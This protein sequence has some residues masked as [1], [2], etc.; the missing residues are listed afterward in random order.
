LSVHT[1]LAVLVAALV[2]L[3][4]LAWWL[5]TFD[6]RAVGTTSVVVSDGVDFDP[7]A[8]ATH[9][10]YTGSFEIERARRVEVTLWASRPEPIGALVSLVEAET[11]DVR[12]GEAT[13]DDR[14]E[15]RVVFDGVPP[16]DYRLRLVATRRARPDTRAQV[17]LRLTARVGGGS[18]SALTIAAVLLAVP[19]V[20][21]TWRRRSRGSHESA[22]M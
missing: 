8:L 13:L 12:E 10:G 6:E 21:R 15:A 9:V 17:Q 20:A 16:G 2:S 11:G 5:G 3:A 4:A 19:W 14:G 18:R 7:R 22:R 1:D